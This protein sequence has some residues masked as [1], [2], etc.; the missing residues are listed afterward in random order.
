MWIRLRQIAVV[1]SD[2]WS[3]GLDIATVLGVEACY[4][5]A[6]V[7]QFGLKNTLWPIGTQFLEVVTPTT[8]GT[9]GG[10]YIERRGGDT[11]YMVITQVDDVT[12][13]RERVAELGVRIAFDL[14]HRDQGHDGIQLHPADTGGSFFEMDQMTM[15]GG[16][17]PGGPWYPAGKSWQ[18][19]V[20]TDM[21]S[22]ISAAELQSPDPDTLARRWGDIAEID[23]TTDSAGNQM[24]QLDNATL[25][26]V[27]AV[28]GRGEGL[29]G[30]D[31]VTEDRDAVLA[32]AKQRGC[33]VTDEQVAVAGLR[34]N[35]VDG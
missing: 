12:R 22:A 30:I 6:G 3:T 27:E 1:A 13:R 8:D 21:V 28:D 35:L 17:E 15:T 20:R 16:D 18:P 11:G 34:V 29:G 19:F 32:G 10:R 7:N 24:L 5:D 2:L 14:D 31:V 33:Y 4:T 23:P 26:F 25:R 9:A